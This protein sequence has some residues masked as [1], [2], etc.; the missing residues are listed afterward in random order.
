[1]DYK[2]QV[3][4]LFAHYGSLVR[5]WESKEQSTRQELGVLLCFTNFPDCLLPLPRG[6]GEAI[7]HALC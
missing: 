5:K 7:S 1:M 3:Y 4:I 6:Q 2:I